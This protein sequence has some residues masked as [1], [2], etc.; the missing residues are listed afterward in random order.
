MLDKLLASGDVGQGLREINSLVL[1]LYS[2]VAQAHIKYGAFPETPG[3]HK[4]HCFIHLANANYASLYYCYLFSRV[5]CQ[6]L[7]SE[8]EKSGGMSNG[9]VAMRYRREI[10]E[11]GGS[12]DAEDMVAAF[13][14]RRYSSKA[15]EEWISAGVA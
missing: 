14:G 5:I 7:F 2:I 12:E 1:A 13:L 6:D 8:F 11:K 10:L 4:Q 15:F 3:I 9:T